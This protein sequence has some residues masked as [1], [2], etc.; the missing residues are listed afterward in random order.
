VR[1]L[2][3][4]TNDIGSDREPKSVIAHKG[5]LYENP[6]DREPHYKERQHSYKKQPVEGPITN[7]VGSD[8]DPKSVIAH[9]GDIYDSSTH[10]LGMTTRTTHFSPVTRSTSSQKTSGHKKPSKTWR[11]TD[12]LRVMSEHRM[13]KI[14]IGL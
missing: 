11:Q 5:D 3:Q 2:H 1:Y 9:K 8:R 13:V 14:T 4:K 12:A 10:R 6:N 7:D